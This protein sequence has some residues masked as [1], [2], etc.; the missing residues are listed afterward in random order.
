M[1]KVFTVLI[2]V[3][4]NY[5]SKNNNTNNQRLEIRKKKLVSP[6]L[7][8]LINLRFRTYSNYETEIDAEC[9]RDK[10]MKLKLK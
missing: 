10:K 8:L 6:G 5:N 4:Y 9:T 3:W 2:I 7:I 1:E